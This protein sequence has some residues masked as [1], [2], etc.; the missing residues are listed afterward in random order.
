MAG[1]V[2]GLPH[3]RGFTPSLCDIQLVGGFLV[4]ITVIVFYTY[5]QKIVA[6]E[7][8]W[9]S[10][11]LLYRGMSAYAV[12]PAELIV[13]QLALFHLHLIDAVVDFLAFRDVD[14][15]TAGLV[16]LHVKLGICK[17]HFQFPFCRSVAPF[18]DLMIPHTS[19]AIVNKL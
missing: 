7:E 14:D 8:L 13:K 10:T 5:H 2:T 18:H 11:I 4:P 12:I 9:H 17:F 15:V 3:Y 19:N 16:D 1:L 6:V